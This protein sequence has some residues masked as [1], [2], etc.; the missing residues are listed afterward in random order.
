MATVELSDYWR[1]VRD[2]ESF[3]YAFLACCIDTIGNWLT[4]VACVTITDKY[5]GALLTSIFFVCKLSPPL[6]F[7]GIVGPLADS[8]NK[9]TLLIACAF[10]AAASVSLLLLPIEGWMRLWILYLSVFFQFSFNSLYEPARGSLIPLLLHESDLIVATTL[11]GLAW[12]TI[13]AFGAMFGGF[14]NSRFGTNAAFIIDIC[15]Y[16]LSAYYLSFIPLDLC[17]IET[18]HSSNQQNEPMKISTEPASTNS[19][20]SSPNSHLI[21]D[22]H[23]T[24][25]DSLVFLSRYSFGIALCCLKGQGALLWGPGDILAVEISQIPHY[26]YHHDENITLGIMFSMVGLG[27]QIG[28]L[29]SNLVTKQE[30][31]SLFFSC[32]TSLLLISV[33]FLLVGSATTLPIILLGTIVR[34]MGSS[35]LWIYSSLLIQIL[36]PTTFQGRIFTI[37]RAI[38]TLCEMSSILLG[39][40]SFDIL[41]LSIHQECLV[42]LTFGG[43]VSIVWLILHLFRYQIRGGQGGGKD[44]EVNSLDYKTIAR[45]EGEDGG[46]DGNE[47]PEGLELQEQQLRIS[48][49]N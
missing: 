10:G 29:I 39:G 14:I 18:K 17:E 24:F 38:Y 11:D 35:I 25:Y 16:F 30:E 46:G 40:F 37:E 15:S 21:S 4:F 33:S 44:S 8:M 31:R 1:V 27:A 2:N 5:G 12:S 26:Q 49:V 32:I 43:A 6:L 28:P 13:G 9:R 41:Q 20:S 7:A 3:R 47:P 34:A 42:M 45:E 22:L 36:V 48:S 23:E 19:S